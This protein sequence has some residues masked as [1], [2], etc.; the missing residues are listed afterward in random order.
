M[1]REDKIKMAIEKGITCDPITG[2]VYGVTGKELSAKLNGYTMI[3]MKED[4]KRVPLYAHQFV[5]YCA[6]K[7]IVAQI[8]HINR[9][10]SDNRIE[11]LR[12]TNY[13][14]NAKNKVGKGY[15]YRNGKYEAG[16]RTDKVTKY[17]GSFN[18]EQEAHQAYLDAKK[19]YHNI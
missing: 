14:D 3:V 2:K 12:E 4:N 15:C 10:R 16:I 18:T 9:D 17:L 11:N 7:K 13:D 8:D 5:Y 19:I 1:N 6:H